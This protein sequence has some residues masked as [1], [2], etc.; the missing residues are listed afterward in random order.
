METVQRRLF[1]MQDLQY[2]DFHSGLMPTIDK[3]TVIGVR[4]PQL[5][6]FAV[7]FSKTQE[8][9]SFLAELPHTYYEENN[10]HAFLVERINDYESAVSAADTFL[11][12]VDNWATCDMM[13]PKVFSKNTDKLIV[14]IRE[15]TASG[16]TYTKRFGLGMLKRY[17]LGKNLKNEYLE[18][19]ADIRSDEYYVNMM[20]AWFFAEALAKNYDE[21]VKYIENGK[22]GVWTHN[23]A[24]QKAVESRRISDDRKM[25]LKS[26]KR[27]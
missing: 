15:W 5:R 8:A 22:L 19:A 6:R 11:P 21:T 7:E 13:Q 12:Y 16:H 1:G 3:N 24:I 27:K 17:Y 10:L 26:L 2:R 9:R 18:L 14:K 25:Y 23:K 4:I 20:A